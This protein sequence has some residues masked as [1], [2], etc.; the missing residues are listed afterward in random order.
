M[1]KIKINLSYNTYN[2]LIHDME[3]FAFHIENGTPNKNLFYNTIIKNMYLRKQKESE[4]IR[5]RLLSILNDKILSNNIINDVLDDIESLYNYKNE[6]KTNRSHGYYISLRPS[7]ALLGMYEEIENNEFKGDSI[8]NYYRNLFNDYARLP[9]DERERIAYNDELKLIESAIKAKRTIRLSLNQNHF[10]CIP[11][12]IVRTNDE[13]YNYLIAGIRRGDTIK[14]FSL[15]LYKCYNAIK[16]KN[17][18]ELA[19]DEINKFNELLEFGPRNIERRTIISKIKLTK[20]GIKLFKSFY[21]NRPIPLAIDDDVYTFN[22]SVDNLFVYFSRFG[23]E[24]IILE[25]E[26][27]KGQMIAFHKKAYNKYVNNS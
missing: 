22:T 6:D 24:A 23:K 7:K 3:S 2:L 11:Y 14:H 1:E 9:Q 8:S 13:L 19:K 27:F 21:L 20:K 26:N 5:N 12:A 17:I 18:Y 25:P 10:E 4:A 16:T 15:H